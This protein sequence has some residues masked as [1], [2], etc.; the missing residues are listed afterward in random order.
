[1]HYQHYCRTLYHVKVN[2]S[3]TVKGN[4]S[5]PYNENTEKRNE[6]ETQNNK[7]FNL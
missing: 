5:S 3:N 4:H 7:F 6:M 2:V 1:M